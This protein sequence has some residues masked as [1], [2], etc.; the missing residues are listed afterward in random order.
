M[1]V[2]SPRVTTDLL[3]DYSDMSRFV[4][5]PKWRDLPP[6]EKAIAI[7]RYIT[8]RETG[9]YPVQGTY[10][11]P[12]PGPEYVFYDERDLIKLLNVHGHGYCGLLSPTLDGIYAHAGF[13]DSRIIRMKENH[14]CVTEVFY[15]GG[16]HYF[17]VDLRGML[18]KA[19][20]SVADLEEACSMRELWTDPPHPVEP[21]YPLDDKE[22]M[23]ESYARCRL[24]RS[25]SWYKNGHTMDFVLRPG[26]SI[27]RFWEPQDGRWF[28]PWP[29]AGG[30]NT[31]FLER[32]FSTEPRGL[33]C[34][35]PGWSKWTHGNGLLSYVP[36][37][38]EGYADFEQG[39]CDQEGM[40]LTSRGVESREGGHATFAVRTPYI[41][42]GQVEEMKPP[43]LMRDATTILF[44]SLGP[45]RVSVSTD[46]GGTWE[47][48]GG[49]D[50]AGTGQIDLTPQVV[51]RYGYMIR[52]DFSEQSGLAEL[53]LHTWTQL[54]PPSLPRLFAGRNPLHFAT[55]D[56]YG[57]HTSIEEIR[58]NL[59]DPA[60]LERYLV[61]LDGDY[62]PLRENAKIRGEIVLEIK[63]RLGAPIQWLTAGGYF[64]SHLGE[65]A[66]EN[67][68]AI[69]YSTEGP[70]GP[71]K[72]I[73][74]A[75]VP[76]WVEDWH[77]GMDG[78]AVLDRPAETIYLKYI[79]D[80][81]LNQIWIYAHCLEP[82]PSSVV[83]VIHGYEIDGDLHEATFSFTEETDYEIDCP[84]EPENRF[85]RFAVD[86]QPIK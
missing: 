54:S 47:S 41:I 7:W 13:A 84:S 10:E 74:R 55:G 50:R 86:N 79:G 80:P 3:P 16:W 42:V 21:F 70:N 38:H 65:K 17:D 28:H 26:E 33:K 2:Y 76:T 58:L 67:C 1:S 45:L 24:E 83:E 18:F 12:D 39:V 37:L 73:C 44:Q 63:G 82:A 32:R 85:I 20:G 71:W 56:R 30:F 48:V 62:Q 25:H 66:T 57:Y 27:T 46:R 9:L 4:D 59:R 35:H 36:K 14:H 43:A 40:S 78:K 77:H 72:E 61:E 60:Q 19:D 81:G 22:A 64:H 15:D 23:F 51:G 68:S 49:I 6:A 5:F 29:A 34:K 75:S 11:D 8:D 69:L 53:A 52:F 31:D